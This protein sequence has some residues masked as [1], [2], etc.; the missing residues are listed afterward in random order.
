MNNVADGIKILR[1]MYDKDDPQYNGRRGCYLYIQKKEAVLL[2][3]MRSKVLQARVKA[4]RRI[5]VL[6]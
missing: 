3:D 5:S 2:F 1:S 4:K 6:K